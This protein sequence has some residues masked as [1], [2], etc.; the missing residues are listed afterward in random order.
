MGLLNNVLG[1]KRYQFLFERV[2]R[3]ALRGMNYGRASD[4]LH[5]GESALLER[6]RGMIT[7]SSPVLFD[8]GANKGEFTKH[9]LEIWKDKTIQLYAFEPSQKTFSILKSK[10]PVSDSVLLVN[11]GMSDKE[12]TVELFYD[13]EGSGLASVYKRDLSYHNIDFSNHEKI[14]LTTLDIFC[15]QH[16]IDSIDF[17]K[18]DVEGHELAVLKGGKRMFE[19]GR[20]GMV[21]FEFG[22]CNLD[23]KSFFRDYYYFFSKDYDLYR[24]L[25]DGLRPIRSYSERLEVFLSA[26]YLAIHK[27]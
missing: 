27:R 14:E 24:I 5:N 16:T 2:Y 13:R 11:K 6:V 17:L 1:K 4:Y 8:V 20:I 18:L 21:Q 19:E 22:G 10:V 23:S 15:Q 3:F 9:I 26:N 12:E 25:T 7:T